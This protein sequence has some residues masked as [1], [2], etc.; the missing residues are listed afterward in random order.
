MESTGIMEPKH[1][2]YANHLPNLLIKPL[3]RSREQFICKKLGVYHVY[4]PA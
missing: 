1:V 4:V 2:S 3:E